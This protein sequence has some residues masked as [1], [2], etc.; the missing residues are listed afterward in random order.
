M[1]YE[2]LQQHIR[3]L[4]SLEAADTPI[5]NCYLG[6]ESPYREILN[7]QSRS[8]TAGLP[9]GM[10]ASF[11]EILGYLEVFL[12]TSIMPGTKGVACFARWGDRSF[13]LPL[14]FD[15]TFPNSIIVRPMPQIHPL[16]QLR[17]EM[18]CLTAN[19]DGM[20]IVNARG[21]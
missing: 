9:M 18:V 21:F 12:G 20:A 15:V 6:L 16:I 2:E 8:I 3:H 7:E 11:W 10:R 1:N 5:V 4:E 13:F 19:P 17:D 14:Q